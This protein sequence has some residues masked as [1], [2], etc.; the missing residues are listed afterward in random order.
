MTLPAVVGKWQKTVHINQMKHTYSV[1]ANAFQMSMQDNGNP[2]EWDWGTDQSRANLERVVETYLIP[3]LNLDTKNTKTPG[4]YDSYYAAR[5]KNGTTLLFIL[6]GCTNP[7]TCDPISIT[8]LYI[9]V[10]PKGNVL[11][12]SDK[13]R[14]YSREDFILRFNRFSTKLAFFA[15]GG[16]STREELKNNSLYACNKNIPKNM[17]FNCGALIFYDNWEIKDDY[18]W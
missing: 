17:R 3:Y 18:P 16:G 14:D 13:S 5:L 4:Q 10:S 6:D 12:M 15:G 9:I 11:P 8:S 7:N 1:I 2:K